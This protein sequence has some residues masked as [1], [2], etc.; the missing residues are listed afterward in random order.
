MGLEKA[1][2]QVYRGRERMI[3]IGL[4]G[5][6]GSG[7]TKVAEILQKE[8][9]GDLDL[10]DTKKIDYDDA[11]ERKDKIIK[12]FMEMDGHWKKFEVIE[13][14]SIILAA[15]LERGKDSFVEYLNTITSENEKSTINIGEKVKLIDAIN[16]MS[17]MFEKAQKVSL[18]IDKIQNKDLDKYYEFYTKE[19]REYKKS[20]KSIL[21]NYTCF[22]VKRS[23]L[24]GKQ[25]KRYHLYTY[26]MQEMGNNL[27]S[28]GNPFEKK[29]CENK[30]RDFFIRVDKVIDIIN[31]QIERTA[32]KKKEVPSTRIC[33]DAIRNPYE[34]LYFKD[35][36]KSFRLMA[37]STKD[38][39]RRKRLKE[40]N[41]E[42]LDNLD[43]VEYATKLKRAEE[44]F[45][46]QNIQGCLEVADIHVYNENIENRKYHNLTKQIIKYIAL[47]LHPA[48]VTPTHIERCMQLAYNAKYNSGCLSRQVGAVV[49][50]EDYSVQSVG[51]NDVPKGQV[52]CNLRDISSFCTNK[53][54]ESFSSYEIEDAGFN[55]VMDTLNTKMKGKACGRCKAFCFKDIYNGM[56]DEKNQVYTRALHA[57]ENAFLQISK[58]GGTAVKGGYLF[59]TASPCELCAKKAYQLGIKEIYYIDPYPGIS[60]KHILTF[61]KND[62]PEMNLFYGAI[63]TAYLDFYGTRIPA[64]DELEMLTNISVKDVAKGKIE[65]NILQYDDLVYH[66]I[67]VEFRFVKSRSVIENSRK[68]C[69]TLNNSID[70]IPK[71]IVWTGS[72]YDGTKLSDDETDPGITLEE[73]TGS[74]PYAY[75]ILID[76]EK[77][78]GNVIRYKTITSAKDEKR[79]MEPYLA[80]MVKNKTEK[81]KLVLVTPVGIVENV[82][83]TIYAD[84]SMEIKIKEGGLS[85]TE[86]NEIEDVI[87]YEFSP[88]VANV[89]YTY[90]IEWDFKEQS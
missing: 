5:R 6:T 34:A 60:Q 85:C 25:Q 36:Y 54:I 57:E 74:M 20:F 29:F 8:N 66:N 86:E 41:D 75:N 81:L 83:W 22:E 90:A 88:D 61:G 24:K 2:E 3:I 15:A 17:Y 32:K 27:R 10:P 87:R 65:D 39:D 48:L 64:K 82:R 40:L 59:T 46:H 56:E 53:D 16:K 69:F 58:Y 79:V 13:M 35:K 44:V 18:N 1:V 26:L 7:C 21:D 71:K 47:M 30:F 77:H 23:R 49:T 84:L 55:A 70:V 51:W 72:T 31:K 73:Q 67:E 50:R 11:E 33:I 4:T 68:V 78:N 19:I 9:F 43:N 89:N 62:N 76:R 38:E 14:S 12:D 37:I 28:S 63:G 80:H 52:S 42:E 45:Y